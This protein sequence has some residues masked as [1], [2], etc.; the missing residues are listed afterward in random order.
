[1]NKVI[2]ILLALSVGGCSYVD[3][4]TGG[5]DNSVLPGTREDAIPG[6]KQ[7]PEPDTAAPSPEQ[8]L[9]KKGD[10]NCPPADGTFSDPQ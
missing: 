10:A 3:R 8:P 9:C 1:M 5:T 4:L 2:F 6:K 7:F